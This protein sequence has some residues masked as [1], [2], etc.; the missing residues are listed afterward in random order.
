MTCKWMINS[1]KLAFVLV[2]VTVAIV[3]SAQSGETVA[4]FLKGGDVRFGQIVQSDS[5]GNLG[6]LN[7]CGL[8]HIKADDIDS[9]SLKSRAIQPPSNQPGN[10]EAFQPSRPMHQALADNNKSTGVETKQTGYYNITSVALLF[11][12]GQD[13]F[14]PLPSL[15]M[16][17]GWQINPNLFTGMGVGYEYYEW[18]VIP[19]FAE[20]KYMRS[21]DRVKPFCSL[22]LGYSIP[23]EKPSESSDYYNVITDYIGGVLVSPEAGIR[24]PMGYTNALMLS[25]GYHYQELSYK[26][27][28]Q[29][30]YYTTNTE[31]TIHTNYNRISIKVGFMFR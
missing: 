12:Q 14:I 27:T 10:P 28:Y 7:E 8:F 2:L 29:N 26:Q 3:S 6:L 17:N 25:L 31:S 5:L 30:W 24:I 20:V 1:S 21:S 11:G 9:I 13:G 18:G 22:K 23:A 19:F 16:V 15:T 4:I